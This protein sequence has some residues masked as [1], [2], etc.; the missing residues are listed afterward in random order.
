MVFTGDPEYESQTTK[1]ESFP[2]SPV[3]IQ[4]LSELTAQQE[5]ILQCPCKIVW[6]LCS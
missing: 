1:M 2:V 6:R 4:R 3:T 5:I